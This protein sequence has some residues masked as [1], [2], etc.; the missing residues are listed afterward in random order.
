ME[1][2][3]F[4]DANQ[5]ISEKQ[6]QE[7]D[8]V[9]N[10]IRDTLVDFHNYIFPKYIRNYKDYLWFV[11]ERMGSIEPWQSNVNYPMVSSTID[12]M[13]SNIFDFWYEFWIKELWLK[14]LCTKAFDFRWQWRKVFKE[15]LKEILITWKGYVKDYF[16][17]EDF[18]ENFF[19][20]EI[21][22][23]IKTPSL[24]YLSIFD[25]LYDRSKWLEESSYKVIRTF[26]TW[27]Q[28]KKKVIPL[29]REKYPESEYPSI[30]KKVDWWL[31]TYKNQ[32]WHRFSM[33]DYNPVK[34]L[35]ATQQWYDWLKDNKSFYD[36]P[37]ALKYNDL[38]SWYANTQNW[39][40][41]DAKNYFLND[42]ESSYELVEYITSSKRYIFVNGNIVYFWEKKYNLWDIREA[43]F[44]SIPWTGN[45]M[46]AAD[47]QGSLQ[48]LQN[49][50]WNAF[51]DNIK[52]NLWPMFKIT[53]NLPQSKNWSLEFK[54]FRAIKVTWQTDIEKVQ[55]G[56]D[57][58]NPIWF[59][60]KVDIASQ[61]DF[62]MNNYLTWGWG[63]IERVQW[64][65]DLKYNQYK[66]RL[67]P[68]IDSIDQMMANIA[69]SW[70]FM[71]LKFFT[72]E[73]LNSLWILVEDQYDKDD[74]WNEKFKTFTLNKIDILD[75]IDETNITFSYNSLDK[76]TKESVR[77]NL[78]NNLWPI[79]QYSGN[80]VNYDQLWLI[81]AWMDFD[82]AKIF[83]DKQAIES[84]SKDTTQN[85]M[86]EVTEEP[87]EQETEEDLQ[88]Q[89]NNII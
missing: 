66:A 83:I 78:I 57:N 69:R 17:K 44:S 4:L 16:I 51:I 2:K 49:T 73:E 74:N 65:I 1:E 64:G 67:N 59:M 84:A 35:M 6:K 29:L 76:Q 55:L 23:K 80:K 22:N 11:A 56:N 41:E 32:F 42:K 10:I 43:T 53:G 20:K 79:L 34:S 54:A 62:A 52:L 50:L 36:L 75:I 31:T 9:K 60:D 46:W 58:F 86:M 5:K 77:N 87:I 33:Y 39:V 19:W 37:N 25:V 71:Y 24:I 68:I 40:R 82:P 72:K 3:D 70:I 18:I 15:V 38:L 28:I 30:D 63:S 45:A 27:E 48:G 12:T 81:M 85:P 88:Q 21:K 47:K 13:F 7:I 8:N 26:T 61:K 89:L 14:N